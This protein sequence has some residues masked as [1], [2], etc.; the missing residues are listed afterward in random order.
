MLLLLLLSL[1]L[2]LL[3]L[4]SYSSKDI[5]DLMTESEKMMWFNHPNVMSL[6]GVCI[7]VGEAPYVV[8]PFMINGSLLAYLKKNRSHFTSTDES[9]SG[10]VS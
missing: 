1:L 8:M 4:G 5:N 2:L 3:Y 6:I 10:V 7:D 9:E